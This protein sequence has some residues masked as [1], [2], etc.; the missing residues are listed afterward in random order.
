[1]ARDNSS[2]LKAPYRKNRGAEAAR[3][4]AAVRALMSDR[5]LQTVVLRLPANHAWLSAGGRSDIIDIGSSGIAD[6]VVTHDDVRLIT[7]VNEV[8]RLLEEEFSALSP[9]ATVL[10]WSVDR[11]DHLP[12]G[13]T[14]A[15]DVADR[16]QDVS[17]IGAELALMR[18]RL[19]AEEIERAEALGRDTA[20]C[21]TDALIDTD[22]R[23]SEYDAISRMTGHLLARGI[24]PVVLLAA[25][26]ERL[27]RHR[28][29]LPTLEA[30][31]SLAMVVTCARRDG[32]I[33]NAT[34]FVSHGPLPASQQETLQRLLQV[35]VA[36]NAGTSAGRT[37]GAVFNEGID[38]YATAG[39]A[40]DEW[41]NHHQGGL[42]GY[43]P[44]EEVATE[45]SETLISNGQMFAWNPSADGLKIED[46]IL[47]TPAGPQVLTVDP[48][49]PSTTV[50]GMVRPL[51]L[52][53]T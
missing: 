18:S 44:R 6:F 13:P 2:A 23:M 41:Q 7:H 37:V 38:A 42:A 14:T 24:E 53:I 52:E 5:G 30:L 9:S 43:L 27:T 48:R 17:F 49:W 46:T 28:H 1:V 19:T 29:P 8:A 40:H 32:L 51:I 47:T 12:V 50:E 33:I 16:P 11:R 15:W 25:G 35:D 4:V 39:F 45:N 36:F 26:G 21:M 31:G 20:E 3:K 34:R 22:S 10:Q